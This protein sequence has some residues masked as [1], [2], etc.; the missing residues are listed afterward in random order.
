MKQNQYTNK[1][2]KWFPQHDSILISS[3]FQCYDY[4]FQNIPGM[5]LL[6][7]DAVIKHVS[8]EATKSQMRQSNNLWWNKDVSEYLELLPFSWWTWE[9]TCL[10]STTCCSLKKE[11]PSKA[12]FQAKY[13]LPATKARSKELHNQ[14]EN[15]MYLYMKSKKM[16]A[17]KTNSQ[18]FGHIINKLFTIFKEERHNLHHKIRAALIL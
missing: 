16:K 12:I 14:L 17:W 8:S 7:F 2:V 10:K 1:Y 18:G 5:V 11:K 4:E 13:F 15:F 6:I 9:S 3:N